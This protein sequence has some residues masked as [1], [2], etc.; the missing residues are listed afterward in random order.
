[1]TETLERYFNTS[2]PC[3]RDE[4]YMLP[5]ERRL[6]RVMELV[7]RRRWF[8]LAA[9]RQTG[10]TTS[11]RWIVEHERS[12]GERLAVWIDLESAREDPVV[13][14]AMRSVLSAIDRGLATQCADLP[15]PDDA[16]V[17][18]WLR[19][20]TDAVVRYLS[21]VCAAS[22]KPVVL[23]LDEADGLVGAAMVSFLTQLRA[24]YVSRRDAPAPASVALVGMRAIRDYTLS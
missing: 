10:K 24:L 13:A 22:P 1:V 20:P 5:P 7:G 16:T 2:G 11:L 9:G 18:A 17:E 21:A 14:T 23:L 19:T 4:H 6:G 8:V 15:R 12:Q 3:H